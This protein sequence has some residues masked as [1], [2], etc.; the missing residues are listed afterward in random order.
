MN[1]A[2]FSASVDGS[3]NGAFL[4][5]LIK[6]YKLKDCYSL[7]ISRPLINFQKSN[8]FLLASN[9]KFYQIHHLNYKIFTKI[10]DNIVDYSMC[11]SV[12]QY[13]YNNSYCEKVIDFLIR[14]TKK[15]I[16]IY[17]IKNYKKKNAY[18]ERVRERQ[19]LTKIEFNKKYKNT[20]I[21][22]YSKLFF[23]RILYKLRKKYNFN[24]QFIPL[25]VQALDS[26]FGYCLLIKKNF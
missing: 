26:N 22:F 5:Y 17:D 9:L 2:N 11:N 20:P 13:F 21:K 4:N 23:K 10:E 16:L 7:E 15:N 3:G 6:K 14:S 19:N 1:C 25:T 24:Y 8:Q 18:K 12:F